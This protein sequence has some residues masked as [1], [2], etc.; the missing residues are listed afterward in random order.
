VKWG[1]ELR[2]PNTDHLVIRSELKF[3]FGAK[4]AGTVKMEPLSGY[5]L[6]QNHWFMSGP[7]N[8]PADTA[9]F[10]VLGGS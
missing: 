10:G 5:N 6:A 8:N 7:G 4:V 2:N 3:L 1:V 9:W